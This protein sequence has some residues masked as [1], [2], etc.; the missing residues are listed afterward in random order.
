[1]GSFDNFTFAIVGV[2]IIGLTA[3]IFALN[4]M[5]GGFNSDNTR[6]LGIVLIASF[7]TVLAILH[8]DSIASAF[9]ILGAIAGYL[10]GIKLDNQ[11]PNNSAT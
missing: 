6:I 2:L 7:T 4:L 5:R 8:K 11:N 3:V 9:G 10:F 1:M